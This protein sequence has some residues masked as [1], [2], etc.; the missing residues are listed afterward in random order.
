MRIVVRENSIGRASILLNV[1]ISGRSIGTQETPQRTNKAGKHDHNCVHFHVMQRTLQLSGILFA[2]SSLDPAFPQ[3]SPPAAFHASGPSCDRVTWSA[4]VLRDYPTIHAACREV[5]R[6]DESYLVKLDCEVRRI[7]MGGR[8]MTVLC[9]G[10]VTMALLPPDA[11]RFRVANR[12]VPAANLVPADRFEIFI[13]HDELIARISPDGPAN[14]VD[15]IRIT[16]PPRPRTVDPQFIDL[17]RTASYLPSIGIAG[18]A[19]II[20]AVLLSARRLRRRDGGGRRA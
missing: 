18:I 11:L 10:G 1:M 2:L 5:L 12:M 3:G 7:A 20:V 15:R 17:P 4:P 16:A 9:D 19:L 8:Q 6:R 14:R 13:P